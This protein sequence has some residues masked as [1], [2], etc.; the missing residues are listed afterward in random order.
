MVPRYHLNTPELILGTSIFRPRSI[1][2]GQM[3]P[4]LICSRT[5]G[6]TG[7]E[8]SDSLL[9]II[10]IQLRVDKF[11][12]DLTPENMGQRVTR[13]VYRRITLLPIWRPLPPGGECFTQFSTQIHPHG[14]NVAEFQGF[15]FR[16]SN[17]TWKF[18]FLIKNNIDYISG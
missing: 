5:D 10:S 16:W 9:K 18:R 12:H 6:A 17:G 1:L 3:W 14:P 11:H 2:M 7:L 13:Y 4:S 15:L 8:N